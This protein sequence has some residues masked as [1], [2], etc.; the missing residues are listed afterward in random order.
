[1]VWQHLDV[2]VLVNPTIL[3]RSPCVWNCCL[4]R[5]KMVLHQGTTAVKRPSP[6]SANSPT[7]AALIHPNNPAVILPLLL[8][9]LTWSIGRR[10]KDEQLIYLVLTLHQTHDIQSSSVENVFSSQ[11]M[12]VFQKLGGLSA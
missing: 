4:G 5:D 6:T 10:H 11:N 1:M 12:T 2:G 8:L 7:P 9:G 3:R